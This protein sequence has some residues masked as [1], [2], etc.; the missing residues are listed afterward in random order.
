MLHVDRVLQDFPVVGLGEEDFLLP[1]LSSAH[2]SRLN[3]AQ[4]ARHCEPLLARQQLAFLRQLSVEIRCTPV[5][6][7]GLDELGCRGLGNWVHLA[8]VAELVLR[9]SQAACDV[10]ASIHELSNNDLVLTSDPVVCVPLCAFA[11]DRLPH[12]YEFAIVHGAADRR[13]DPA[14]ADAFE[15]AFTPA[16]QIAVL[17]VKVA[18]GDTRA[19]GI[20]L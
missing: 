19:V 1:L 16:A 10:W 18:D 6:T 4:L 9:C 13:L 12:A 20:T 7:L 11:F 17:S 5:L 8:S 2:L 14:L 15:L 3:L